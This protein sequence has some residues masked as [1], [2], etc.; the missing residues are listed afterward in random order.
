MN[1]GAFLFLAIAVAIAVL[2][3]VAVAIGNRFME[4]ILKPLTM[5][6]LVCVAVSIDPTSDNARWLLVIGLVLSMAGDIFLMLPADLFVPGLASFLLAHIFYVVAL[7]AL[8][9]SFGGV[10][11]GLV[12]AGSAALVVG[13]RIVGGAAAADP[14]LRVPVIAYMAAISAM[15]TFAFGTGVFFAIVGALLFFVSDA[16][17]GWTR[18][19]S[20]FAR[21]RQ[22]VMIT[23]HLGQMGL[24]L[25]LI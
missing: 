14:A 21:S 19:V 7:A 1:A 9:V 2:D 4:Y 17:L 6:A 8:G 18:F 12:I 11:T 5:V 15:V 25:A 23:Y 20:E 3:W 24:V 13:R 22:L 10:I 16:V